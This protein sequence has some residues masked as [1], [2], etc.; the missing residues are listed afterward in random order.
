MP[1]AL[2]WVNA[3]T[4]ASGSST[5]SASDLAPVATPLHVSGGDVSS[6]SHVKRSG[7]GS[8]SVN[9]GLVIRTAVAAPASMAAVAY[10]CVS[11]PDE[12]LRNL[13]QN[14]RMPMSPATAAAIAGLFGF[15]PSTAGTAWRAFRLATRLPTVH[16]TH[17]MTAFRLFRMLPA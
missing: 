13:R 11:V 2:Q 6:P 8:P 17:P 9:A 15:P 3:R 7:S 14:M 1:H 12:G 4:A 5:S 16:V 10:A